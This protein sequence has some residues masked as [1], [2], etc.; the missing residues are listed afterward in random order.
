MEVGRLL[1]LERELA[2]PGDVTVAQ[3]STLASLLTE[4]DGSSTLREAIETY[5]S[6][7]TQ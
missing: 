1:V 4:Q 6:S 3:L 7:L 2:Q 5:L